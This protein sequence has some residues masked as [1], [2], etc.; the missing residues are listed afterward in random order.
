MM[1]IKRGVIKKKAHKKIL[2]LAR[3]YRGARSRRFKTANEAVMHAGKYAHRDRRQKKRDFRKLWIE[4]INAACRLCG[5]SYSKFINLLNKN[6]IKIDRKNLQLLAVEDFEVF[7][8][9]V[10]A[11]K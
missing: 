7:K 5:I 1:R 4:R 10:E 8:M 6:N 11:V 2:K 3:G 9:L